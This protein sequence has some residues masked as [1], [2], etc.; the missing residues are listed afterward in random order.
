[1]ALL[2][3]KSDVE[4]RV[5]L[6]KPGNLQAT[7]MFDYLSD[8]PVDGV[9]DRLFKERSK[10][11]TAVITTSNFEPVNIPSL[12]KHWL[13]AWMLRRDSS[14]WFYNLLLRNFNLL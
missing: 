12:M 2:A 6:N 10:Q 7:N 5:V 4:L 11:W 8:F 13:P 1:M 9:D 14:L 3:L